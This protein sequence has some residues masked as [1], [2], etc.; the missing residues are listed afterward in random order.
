MIKLIHIAPTNLIGFV[1]TNYNKGFNMVLTHLVLSDT[2]YRKA[3]KQVKGEKILDNSFFELGYCMEPSK[4]VAAA[5]LVDAT[6]LIC[7][8]GTMQGLELFKKE[9]YKVMC[10]PRDANQFR[11]FMYSPSIDYVGLSEE[12]FAYRHCPGA[13]Y[14]VLRDNLNSDMPRKKIHLLGATDSICELAMLRPFSEFIMSWDS[15]AAVWQGHLGNQLAV[16]TR[17][18]CRAV[19]FDKEVEWNLLIEDNIRFIE[20]QVK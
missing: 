12:H 7:P 8:D 19:E 13:R 5:K 10:V 16:Q 20:E 2:K 17:K 4:M 1:D 18:D 9:G 11:D 15:S 3:F 14:E 6:T